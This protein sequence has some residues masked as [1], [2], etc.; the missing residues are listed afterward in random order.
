MLVVIGLSTPIP[1]QKK[2]KKGHCLFYRPTKMVVFELSSRRNIVKKTRTLFERANKC[3]VFFVSLVQ[4]CL[5][6]DQR[7][8][9]FFV[10]FAFVCFLCLKKTNTKREKRTNGRQKNT[11]NVKAKALK[12]AVFLCKLTRI[13]FLK[14]IRF[15]EEKSEKSYNH[16]GPIF[17]A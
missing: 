13:F 7:R 3:Y 5:R 17:V 4:Y 16:S 11:S 8:I 9:T 2:Q 6:L 14:T 1:F 15:F 10:Q 12:S